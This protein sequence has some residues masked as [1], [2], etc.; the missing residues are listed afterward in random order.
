MRET[1]MKIIYDVCNR[2]LNGRS[3]LQYRLIFSGRSE[4]MTP[5]VIAAINGVTDGHLP[6]FLNSQQTL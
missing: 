6:S 1:T 3:P 4:I 5:V 2:Q